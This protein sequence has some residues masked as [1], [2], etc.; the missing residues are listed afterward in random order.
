MRNWLRALPVGDSP[1]IPGYLVK[2]L[3]GLAVNG[4]CSDYLGTV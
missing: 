3:G 4:G 2:W 1:L